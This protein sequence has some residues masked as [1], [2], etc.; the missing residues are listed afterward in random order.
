MSDDPSPFTGAYLPTIHRL[1]P[2]APDAEQGLLSSC[3][4]APRSVVALCLTHGIKEEHF[5]I[6]AHA[7]IYRKIVELW[8]KGAAIDFI[9]LTTALRDAGELDQCGGAAFISMLFTFMPT[10]VNAGYYIKI[11]EEKF[12]LR[13]LVRVCTE[14]A[15]RSYD[16]QD[17]PHGLLAEAHGAV[18]KL[19]IRT[20]KANKSIRQL[21]VEAGE[22]LE[23]R[24]HGRSP[25]ILTGIRRL[26]DASPVRPGDFLLIAG[27]RKSGKSCLAA[28]IIRR[29]CIGGTRMPCAAFSLEMPDWQWVDRLI[30][31]V[32]RISMSGITRGKLTMEEQLDFPPTL[33]VIA[34]APLEIFDAVYDLPGILARLRQLKAKHPT[35]ALAVVDYCQL[36]E[37]IAKKHET[38]QQEVAQVSRSLKLIAGE[39]EIALIGLSQLNEDGATRE[40]RSLEQDS[41]AIWKVVEPLDENK[42]PIKGREN[43]RTIY[44]PWQRN[45]PPNI[46]IR[47]KFF[48]N[49]MRFSEEEPV[50]EEQTELLDAPNGRGQHGR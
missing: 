27:P 19:A 9:I 21:V 44:V 18:T 37:V 40:S 28:D 32:G 8:N 3:L 47:M 12:M 50:H 6:P 15:S 22:R 31:N 38:R 26:D 4:N 25:Q 29:V 10:A 48:G 45:G 20:S 42:N 23:E 13:E 16:E 24:T 1:L 34:K 14:Y 49:Y 41:T 35:L 7:I 17:D 5:H 30:A 33:D 46:R 11:V 39:L 2:Q 43:E 36:V